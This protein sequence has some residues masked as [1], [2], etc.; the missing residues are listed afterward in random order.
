MAK[1]PLKGNRIEIRENRTQSEEDLR[2]YN[3]HVDD[4]LYRKIID[5][6]V[7]QDTVTGRQALDYDGKDESLMSDIAEYP[8]RGEGIEIR[9][10]DAD[11]SRFQ[12]FVHPDLHVEFIEPYSDPLTRRDESRQPIS[13]VEEPDAPAKGESLERVQGRPLV[14][15]WTPDNHDTPQQWVFG[16]FVMDEEFEVVQGDVQ[17]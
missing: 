15:G 9:K 10:L 16:Y 14:K 3:I 5:R 13:L 11:D 17:C 1:Y 8:L 6:E 4:D 2:K 7:W 12:I